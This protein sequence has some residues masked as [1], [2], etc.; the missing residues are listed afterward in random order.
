MGINQCATFFH[1]MTENWSIYLLLMEG[2]SLINILNGGIHGDLS[3]LWQK[4]ATSIYLLSNFFVT[5]F[6]IFDNNLEKLIFNLWSSY[7]LSQFNIFAL[8]KVSVFCKQRCCLLNVARHHKY[9]IDKAG[10]HM[11]TIN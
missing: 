8:A 7:N 9:S 5:T 6:W 3:I 4:V 1:H 11:W 10:I 2:F